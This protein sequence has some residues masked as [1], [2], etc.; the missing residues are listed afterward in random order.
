M[1]QM[2]NAMEQQEK[3]LARETESKIEERVKEDK[4]LY[5]VGNRLEAGRARNEL[6]KE[7]GVPESQHYGN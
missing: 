3:E 5:K 1:S 2:L 6:A 4:M 7:A